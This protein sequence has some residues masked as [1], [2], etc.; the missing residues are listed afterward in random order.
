MSSIT[1][2]DHARTAFSVLLAI[3]LFGLVVAA[4]IASPYYLPA[5]EADSV[6]IVGP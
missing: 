4:A 3:V 6:L 5:P 1:Q 2:I